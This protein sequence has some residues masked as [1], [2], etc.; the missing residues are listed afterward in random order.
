MAQCW[1]CKADSQADELSIIQ[2]SAYCG[3]HSVIQKKKSTRNSKI[4]YLYRSDSHCRHIYLG[5]IDFTAYKGSFAIFVVQTCLKHGIM[6]F[7]TTADF[8]GVLYTPRVIPYKG[9]CQQGPVGLE[10]T[11]SPSPAR[12]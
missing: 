11:P 5:I 2:L 1:V 3:N 6:Q 4:I 8:E 12:K 10:I 7:N 9:K